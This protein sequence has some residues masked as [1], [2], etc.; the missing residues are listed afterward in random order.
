MPNKFSSSRARLERM[1]HSRRKII[2]RFTTRNR[3]KGKRCCSL[4]R[5]GGGWKAG[6]AAAH[7][8][9]PM[10]L[11]YSATAGRVARVYAG[12]QKVLSSMANF[13]GVLPE[14][15]A[16]VRSKRTCARSWAADAAAKYY[17]AFAVTSEFAATK[18]FTTSRWPFLLA[19][20]SAVPPSLLNN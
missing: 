3:T 2:Y 11:K 20:C 6:L 12:P 13:K 14:L 4:H 10:L 18:A 8:V 19:S 16:V 5:R 9:A 15:F 1:L 7:S 17:L